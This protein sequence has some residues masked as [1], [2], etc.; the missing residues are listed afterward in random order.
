MERNKRWSK[1]EEKVL[2]DCIK[3]HGNMT[4]GIQEASKEL[5]RSFLACQTRYYYYIPKDKKLKKTTKRTKY[6]KWDTEKEKY[7]FDYVSKNQNNINLAFEHIA[8]K[9]E[10]TPSSVRR[11]Y[12]SLKKN[13]SVVFTTIG[14]KTQSPNTKNIP[15]DS[16]EKPKKHSI[17]S[18]LKKLLKLN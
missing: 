10:T 17:W 9:Y 13:Y 12:Y 11:K 14:K 5:N 18:K 1:E 8:K 3:K 4:I 2:L 15:Y 7:L 6:I 16:S